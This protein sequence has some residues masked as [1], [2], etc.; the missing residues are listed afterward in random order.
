MKQ[1]N[2]WLPS[3]WY[4]YL[5]RVRRLVV[6]AIVIEVPRPTDGN[7]LRSQVHIGRNVTAKSPI[8]P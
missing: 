2:S 3:N 5:L 1:V 8:A 6:E 4:C 7:G